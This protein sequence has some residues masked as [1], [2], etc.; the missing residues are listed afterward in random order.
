MLGDLDST[1][2]DLAIRD[3]LQLCE[4]S[5]ESKRITQLAN[6][7]C[8]PVRTWRNDMG[9]FVGSERLSTGRLRLKRNCDREVN[10]D[11]EGEVDNTTADR[12]ALRKREKVKE[13]ME[14]RPVGTSR[15]YDRY[16]EASS[17]TISDTLAI[18]A[19]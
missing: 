10:L 19:V 11:D 18:T 17:A 9:R 4:L 5:Q 15:M 6:R 3:Y 12:E 7:L 16:C 8:D 1:L 2:V 14:A 13:W